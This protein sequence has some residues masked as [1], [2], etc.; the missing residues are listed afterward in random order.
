M[1]R[2][3]KIPIALS[4]GTL[5]VPFGV[6]PNAHAA[7]L[8]NK[9]AVHNTVLCLA[10]SAGKVSTGTGTVI[11]TTCNGTFAEQWTFEPGVPYAGQ[12]IQGLKQPTSGPFCLD[13]LGNGTNDPTTVDITFCNNTPAQDWDYGQ[14]EIVVP[15]LPGLYGPRCLTASLGIAPPRP[16]VIQPCDGSPSQVWSIRS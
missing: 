12:T 1:D 15:G 11:A 5:L 8:V 2:S 3:R 16:V 9:G 7:L 14:G 10:V 13:R 4:L 6:L